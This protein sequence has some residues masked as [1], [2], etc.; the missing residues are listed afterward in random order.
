LEGKK[1]GLFNHHRANMPHRDEAYL[2]SLV[3]EVLENVEGRRVTTEGEDD[4]PETPAA[5]EAKKP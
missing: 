4:A 3:P 1:P 5:D 2:E